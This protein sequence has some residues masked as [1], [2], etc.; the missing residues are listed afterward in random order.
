MATM[1]I[2]IL[3]MVT[4]N[5]NIANNPLEKSKDMF[6]IEYYNISSNVVTDIT[7]FFFSSAFELSV[8]LAC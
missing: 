1:P 5:P 2:L 4:P 3:S 8:L 7:L 6:N